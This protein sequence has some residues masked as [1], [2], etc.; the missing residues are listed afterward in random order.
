[1]YSIL[2]NIIPIKCENTQYS[3]KTSMADDLGDDWW[4]GIYSVLKLH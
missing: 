1:M 3:A 4:K 2:K